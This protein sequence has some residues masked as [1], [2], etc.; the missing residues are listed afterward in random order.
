M[1]LFLCLSSLQNLLMNNIELANFVEQL[2]GY[3]VGNIENEDYD[4]A[5]LKLEVIREAI[6]KHEGDP[7]EGDRD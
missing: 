4:A 3:L 2:S 6:L 7:D 1:R 5:L